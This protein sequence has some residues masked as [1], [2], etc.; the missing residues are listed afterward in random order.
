MRKTGELCLLLVLLGGIGACATVEAPVTT[1]QGDAQ[2]AAAAPP[3][4][5]VQDAGKRTQH[6][7]S[8]GDTLYSIAWRY[9]HDYRTLASLNRIK[10]P[11]TIYPGQVIKLPSARRPPALQP[12]PVAK[13]Q[14]RRPGRQAAAPRPRNAAAV[15]WQWPVR[16]KLLKA[17]TPT[18][19][20]GISISGRTGQ[21][22]VAAATGTVVYS[23]SGLR[24]YGNLIIIKHND[25][26]L[27]AYAYNRDL[28]VKEG[29][30]VKAGQQIST[31]GI[32]G[33]GTP[34][35]HFE[36]R[37]NG[38]P[39]DPLGQLPRTGKG[40]RVMKTGDDHARRR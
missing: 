22:I 15:R 7:V 16:G 5:S 36:I 19:K 29:E 23:G 20:K 39:V 26:Y 2:T 10:P 18:T 34:V 35:L 31:M 11:Y 37:K 38:K 21:K 8:R 14:P 1:R 32:D 25:T 6:T 28:A 3:R 27:S 13:K 9:S 40:T 4:D 33:K 24:G 12:P 30:T 17:S